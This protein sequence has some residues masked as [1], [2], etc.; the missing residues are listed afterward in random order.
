[1]SNTQAVELNLS[2]LKYLNKEEYYLCL[3]PFVL[4][5]RDLKSLK[6]GVWIDLGTKLPQLQIC[7]NRQKIAS[8]YAGKSGWYLG[9]IEKEL[10]KKVGD[11]RVVLESRV[12]IVDSDSIYTGSWIDIP[13]LSFNYLLLFYKK[14]P[15]AIASLSKASTGYG[16]KILESL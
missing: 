16:L 9:E 6:S 4:K 5:K 7:Q 1:M 2:R 10:P 12:S 13:N 3:E 14:E 8:V 11:K 15:I